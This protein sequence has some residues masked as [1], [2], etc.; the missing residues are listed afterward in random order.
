MNPLILLAMGQIVPLLFFLKNMPLK[1]K[2][3]W[4]KKET[5]LT[6]AAQSY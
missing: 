4:N 1:T 3:P 5:F 2:K 6:A